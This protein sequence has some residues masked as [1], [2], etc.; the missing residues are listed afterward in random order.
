MCKAMI[1]RL[2]GA[3]LAILAVVPAAVGMLKLWPRPVAESLRGLYHP[4]WWWAWVWRWMPQPKI[5]WMNWHDFLIT[6]PTIV[7]ASLVGIGLGMLLYTRQEPTRRWE[8]EP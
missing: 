4:R 8:E 6:M 3:V 1:S 2:L 5:P 7:A